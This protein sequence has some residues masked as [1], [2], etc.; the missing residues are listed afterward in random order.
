MELIIKPCPLAVEYAVLLA[1]LRSVQQKQKQSMMPQAY[2]VWTP[3][4]IIFFLRSLD[5]KLAKFKSSKVQLNPPNACPWLRLQCSC[6]C[7][8]ACIYV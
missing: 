8:V 6:A 2:L 7:G 5:Y 1:P 3:L 4:G